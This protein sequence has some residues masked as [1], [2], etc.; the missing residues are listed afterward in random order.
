MKH[1]CFIY[2]SIPGAILS[3]CPFVSIHHT[4]TK[5]DE[6][7]LGGSVP[8]AIPPAS[9]SDVVGQHH[10]TGGTTFGAALTSY[11]CLQQSLLLPPPDLRQPRLQPVCQFNHTTSWSWG[12]RRGCFLFVLFSIKTHFLFPERLPYIS[13]VCY[14]EEMCFLT[15]QLYTQ[16]ISIVP[17]K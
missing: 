11:H 7:L 9:P 10:R 6:I 14:N 16:F 5:C 12:R 8:A 17:G 3:D 2:T 4:A 15:T 13:M 1:L